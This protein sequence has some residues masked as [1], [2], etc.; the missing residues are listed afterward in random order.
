MESLVTE[1]K[2]RAFDRPD[3]ALPAAAAAIVNMVCGL[4]F[5]TEETAAAVLSYN[6]YIILCS[7]SSH[8][9]AR[10]ATYIAGLVALRDAAFPRMGEM[11]TFMFLGAS[12]EAKY[13]TVVGEALV[14][15]GL[16]SMA[17]IDDHLAKVG[18]L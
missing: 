3:S 18:Y 1:E 5:F 13:N 14:R 17:S 4:E 9:G 2:D 12:T 6:M 10:L 8:A 11:I 7:K 15:A 16:L